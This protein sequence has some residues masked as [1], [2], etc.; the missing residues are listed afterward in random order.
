M[1]YKTGWRVSEIAALTWNQVDRD[2]GIVRLEV[3][4]TKNDDARTAYLMMNLKRYS[5]NNGKIAKEA[6][7]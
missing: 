5:T 6:G 2:N 3:G 4:E 7:N 1:G